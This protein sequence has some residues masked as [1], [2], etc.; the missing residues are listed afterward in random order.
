MTE[1]EKNIKAM[2][3]AI[4]SNELEGHKY[5]DKEKDFLMSVACD[6]LTVEEAVKIIL[7]K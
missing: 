4:H 7:K 3:Y 5:T 2:E 6:E 1:K